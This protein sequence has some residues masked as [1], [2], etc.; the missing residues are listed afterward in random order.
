MS[1][2]GSGTFQINTSGQPVVTGTV[3]SSSAF[4]ALTADLATG[5]STAITKDG[6]TAT[7]VRIPFAQGINSS[8]ATDTTSG[9]TGS[10]YTAG[11][12]GI[13]KSL[14][15]GGTATFSATPIFSA[16]TASSAVATNASK[17]LVSVTNTGTG[18]NVLSASPTLTGTIAGASLS[19]SSLTSG[20]VPYATTAGLLTDSANL[21][22][23][24]TDLT[25]Y[26]LT[27][28]RGGSAVA[29]NTV[30]GASAGASNTTGAITAF[31]DRA[32]NANTS[33]GNSV[34]FGSQAAWKVTTGNYNSAFGKDALFSTTTGNQ[35]V[36]IG[37]AAL[38][39]NTTADNNIGIGYQSAY[40]NSTGASIVAIG[41][42]AL[43]NNLTGSNN[44]AVGHNSLLS[45]TTS[46]N[47]TAIGYQA[48]YSATGAGNQF[49][50]YSSGSAVTTG[51]KNVIIGSYTGSAA[52]ISA[53]GSNYVVLSDGDGNVR[54]T[55]DSSGNVG[56]NTTSPSTYGKFNVAGTT[57]GASIAIT[58]AASSTN[59]GLYITTDAI[60]GSY[61]PINVYTSASTGI[62]AYFENIA[63]ASTSDST[64]GV[65]VAGSAAGDP[66]FTYTVGG[67]GGWCTGLDNSDSDKFKISNSG[68]P[69]TSDYLTI[70]TAGIVTMPA[71]GAGT[72]TFSAAGVISSVSDETWKIKDGVPVDVDSM[73]KKLE[74]GYWYYNDEKKEVFGEERQLGFYAQN[75]NAAIGPE[76]AP[77]PEE[78][79][80]WGYYDRSVLAVTVMSLQKA[81]A[82]IESLTARIA[83]L[84]SR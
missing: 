51:A 83:A 24:G 34:A 61:K 47:L 44:T 72:A 55:I 78:G 15:V 14:F 77:V 31:G 38:L 3:I 64:V 2:N 18:N 4:N 11:G 10:I 48:G 50:G 5:L 79:R 19:L 58:G 73:L 56:I 22:Y 1:Y 30:V 81:L 68:S 75:V 32:L 21:L 17:A 49:F 8:L 46:S 66:K 65:A 28:G 59:T 53:T 69:G 43:I 60:T 52:P 27:V 20:R 23:S 26:G 42:A 7:T 6:Q 41:A 76:A 25:V 37:G 54:Q 39:S 45:N 67:V 33:G 29:G 82:T 35:N 57:A 9:S 80:P 70:T 13:T 40:F 16:L 84:E 74:P 63:N 12:V 62:L 71:Y 36:A